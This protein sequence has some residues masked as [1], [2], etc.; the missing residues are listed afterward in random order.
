MSAAQAPKRPGVSRAAPRLQDPDRPLRVMSLNMLHGFPRFERLAE[1]LDLLAKEIRTGHPD[2]VCLQE[3]PWAP[4]IGNAARY[5]AGRTAMNYVCLRANGNR[6]A[7]LFE[8]GEAILSRYPLRDLSFTELQP[9]AGLFEHRVVL[10]ATVDPPEGELRVSVTHLTNGDPEVN[11]A[12]AEA[13]MICVRSHSEGLAVVAG[14]FNARKDS[15]QIQ[16][17]SRQAV[18]TFRPTQPQRAGN[19]CC[20]DD[21]S[22]ASSESLGERID[23]IFLLA[24]PQHNLRAPTCEL[25]LDRPHWTPR[26][27]LWTSDHAGLPATFWMDLLL[28]GTMKPLASASTFSGQR[29]GATRR[30]RSARWPC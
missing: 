19:T 11:R 14:D 21:L 16:A 9:G 29:V 1:R 2:I 5:L 20:L 25:I 4:R 28:E 26:G 3:V 18:D 24:S 27:W 17:I 15:P 30:T 23:Y 12:Q 6:W 10:G 8:E 7:I 22:S 13:L